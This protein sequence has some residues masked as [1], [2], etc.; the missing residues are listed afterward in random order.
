MRKASPVLPAAAP[1]SSPV[2]HTD[3]GD[4]GDR[5]GHS[6]TGVDFIA[7][8]IQS[9][10]VQGNPGERPRERYNGKYDYWFIF[11]TLMVH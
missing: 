4:P 2:V 7:L 10:S 3:L 1:D 9:Q 8:H 6:V 5:D 11:I